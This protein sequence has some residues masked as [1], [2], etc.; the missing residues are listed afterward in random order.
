M[1]LYE[2]HCASCDHDVEVLVRNAQELPECP[3]CGSQK[4]QKLLSVPAAPSMTSGSLPMA[5]HQG[6]GCGRPQCGTGRCMF[7]E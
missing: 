2:Y 6:G 3:E 4:M 1:P 5:D 7:G